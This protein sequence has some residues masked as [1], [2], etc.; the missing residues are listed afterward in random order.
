[1]ARLQQALREVALAVDAVL[2][3][4]LPSEEG[5]A[6]RLSAAMRYAALAGGKRFRPFLV[7]MGGR[8]FGVEDGQALRV[9]AA[10]EMI[11]CYSL[12]HDDLP[13]MDDDAMRRGRPTCHI[14]FDEATAILAGDALLTLAFE[15]LSGAET[16]PDP[17]V[18]ADLV[19]G[20]AAAAGG[21]GMVAGQMM[22][23]AAEH[24]RWDEA[25]IIRLQELKT[26]ALI[27]FACEAGAILGQAASEG[28]AA[29][30]DYGRNLGL[31]FQI[32]DDLL[33]LEGSPADTGKAVGKDKAA[34]KATLVAA[35]GPEAA[36]ARALALVRKATERLQPFADKADLLRDAA[37]FAVNRRS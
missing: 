16:H 26:A 12:V 21:S 19:R 24:Q 7:V 22:D 1:M 17:A 34:G 28:R 18:R 2:D 3:R 4:L 33:D 11:H 30:R 37:A 14:A 23:L 20:L 9:G 5:S 13:A 10:V 8:L 32:T 31:A 15:V 36:G 29:L 35:L 27:A 25:A 6:E